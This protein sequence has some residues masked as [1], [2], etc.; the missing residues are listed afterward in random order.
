[1][2]K[3]SPGQPPKTSET[4]E[5]EQ[6]PHF[7]GRRKGKKLRAERARVMEDLLPKLQIKLSGHTSTT[8][9]AKDVPAKTKAARKHRKNPTEAEKL[10]WQKVRNRQIA[11]TKF[12]RQV[13]IGDYLVDFL[14]AEYKLIVEI[15]GG[16]HNDSSADE[17]RTQYLKS[18]GYDVIRFW[19][20]DV[21]GNID[22]VLESLTL[23]FSQREREP[24]EEKYASPPLPPGEGR[25]E[26]KKSHSEKINPASLFDTAKKEIWLE[27]GFGNGEHLIEQA[28]DNPDVGFIGCEPFVNGVSALLVAIEKHNVQNIRLWPDD[29]RF[30]MDALPDHCLDRCFILNSDPWPKK[31]HAKRRFIQKE[32]LDDLHRLLKTGAELRMSSDHPVL[33][34]WQLEKTYFHGGFD[35]AAT[36]AD[37]WRQRPDDMRETRYQQKGKKQG[38]PTVFLNFKAL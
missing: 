20:H 28:L 30:L 14:S 25:G 6:R 32:T 37:D 16:Q 11:N 22:G 4:T 10:F 18:Q 21:L 12:R 2:S 5:T 3:T 34:D 9:K 23:T 29:A 26:G 1:M 24:E 19:N 35:W 38:R 15:D 7:Y 33:I 27:I 31:K 36:C 17:K 8:L 13:P